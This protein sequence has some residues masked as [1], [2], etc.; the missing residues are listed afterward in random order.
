MC[1]QEQPRGPRAEARR[2]LSRFW[3]AV[4]LVSAGATSSFGKQRNRRETKAGRGHDRAEA[5]R[6]IL[7][8]RSAIYAIRTKAGDIKIGCTTRLWMRVNEVGGE[9]LAFRF[10]DFDEEWS[11]HA[12]LRQHVARRQEYYHPAPEV[13][14]VVNAM[15]DEWNLPHLEK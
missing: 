15:R 2:G 9:I 6:A 4:N 14:A 3:G 12:S 8:N 11:I 10:G 13:M 5:L 7:G 1:P